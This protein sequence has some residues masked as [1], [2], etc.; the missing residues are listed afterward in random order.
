MLESIQQLES[1]GTVRTSGALQPLLLAEALTERVLFG[2]CTREMRKAAKELK[3]KE[4]IMRRADKTAAFVLI[5]AEE[6]FDKLD[7]ILSDTTKF[8]RLTRNPIEDIKREANKIISTVNAASNAVH[9]P[10]RDFEL[11]YLFVKT[12]KAGNPLRPIISQTPA[13]TY[14][15]AK[16]LNHILTSYIPSSYSLKSSVEF[17]SDPRLPGAGTISLD[18]HFL[19]LF[20]RENMDVQG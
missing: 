14:A 16:R 18:V 2:V 1:R 10:H 20:A 12:H 19:K 6:Y 13:P 11:G 15:L 8:E 9:L 17:L 7:A 5:R 3:E 4:G